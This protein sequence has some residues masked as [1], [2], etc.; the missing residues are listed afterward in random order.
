[1]SGRDEK[2]GDARPKTGRLRLD[3]DVTLRRAA[4][5][6]ADRP[7]P[8]RLAELARQ[9]QAKLDAGKKDD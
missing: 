6:L 8:D 7:I 9:L 1:M 3:L 5:E 4:R 2:D